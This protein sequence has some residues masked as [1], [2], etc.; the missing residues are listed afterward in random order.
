MAYQDY[1]EWPGPGIQ[2]FIYYAF[3]PIAA[4]GDIYVGPKITYQMRQGD[5]VQLTLEEADAII[6]EAED[7]SS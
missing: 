3:P 4:E 6:Q 5:W 2:P 1:R 7:A